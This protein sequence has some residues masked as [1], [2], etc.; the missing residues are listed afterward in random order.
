MNLLLLNIFDSIF[1]AVVHVHS[2]SVMSCQK[3]LQST[4]RQD[5]FLGRYLCSGNYDFSVYYLLKILSRTLVCACHSE[6]IAIA[7]FSGAEL[8]PWTG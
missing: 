7:Y 2:S 3:Y 5:I 4:E 8:L 6:H 1:D